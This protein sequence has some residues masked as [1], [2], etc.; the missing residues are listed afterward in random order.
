M[1]TPL[2]RC[3]RPFSPGVQLCQKMWYPPIST[4]KWFPFSYVSWTS[5]API[6]SWS[7]LLIRFSNLVVSGGE[8]I[9]IFPSGSRGQ[10]QRPCTFWLYIF[11]CLSLFVLVSESWGCGGLRSILLLVML[12]ASH[13]ELPLG[14]R[15]VVG[16][17]VMLALL[18]Y[19]WGGV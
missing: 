15:M 8:S 14:N 18:A 4:S 1:A 2:N 10:R 6:L 19:L 11:V 13:S 12:A 17:A 9:S 7:I 5:Q 16:V 3:E